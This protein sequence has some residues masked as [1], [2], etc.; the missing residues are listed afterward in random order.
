[1][2]ETKQQSLETTEIISLYFISVWCRSNISLQSQ[3]KE[4]LNE[5]AFML[6]NY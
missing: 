6:A 2:V 1:M 3:K 5:L 4:K